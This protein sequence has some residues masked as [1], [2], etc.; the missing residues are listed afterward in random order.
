MEKR[1]WLLV[2]WIVSHLAVAASWGQVPASTALEVLSRPSNA[3]AESA[4]SRLDGFFDGKLKERDPAE[5]VAAAGPMGPIGPQL[6]TARLDMAAGP[7]A[8]EEKRLSVGARFGAT[9]GSG[10]MGGT[11]YTNIPLGF[12]FGIEPHLG[13]YG[14]W[15]SKT[16][17]STDIADIW[18]YDYDMGMMRYGEIERKRILDGG[19]QWLFMPLMGT[20]TLSVKGALYIIAKGGFGIRHTTTGEKMYEENRLTPSDLSKYVHVPADRQTIFN[21]QKTVTEILPAYGVQMAVPLGR[22]GVELSGE[23]TRFHDSQRPEDLVTFGL[24]FRF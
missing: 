9:V 2:G 13:A 6:P 11:L 7:V 20:Y 5:P 21:N 22:S 12:G 15:K 17:Q 10:M 3:N 18:V 4:L 19:S 8:R 16:V 23:W 24:N 14:K 1:D